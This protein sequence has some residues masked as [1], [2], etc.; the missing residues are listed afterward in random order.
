MPELAAQRERTERELSSRIN[1]TVNR[2]T[3]SL[4]DALGRDSTAALSNTAGALWTP[5]EQA[6]GKDSYWLLLQ[7]YLD[8]YDNIDDEFNSPLADREL[9]NQ[10]QLPAHDGIIFPSVPPT[11]YYLGDLYALQ[12]SQSLARTYVAN[13]INRLIQVANEAS[14]PKHAT[15]IPGTPGATPQTLFT[16]IQFPHPSQL[17]W[18]RKASEIFSPGRTEAIAITNTTEAISKGEGGFIGRTRLE[19]GWQ[20]TAIWQT[21]KDERVC[22]I[23]RPLDGKPESYYA[24]LVGAPPAHPRCRCWQTYRLDFRR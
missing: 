12:A 24:P 3:P 6:L 20:V 1:A 17:D 5:F 11:A 8:A 18:D 7:I 9:T 4:V 21:E 14:S 22:P 19:L 16:P 2:F 15:T 23:C 13:T 10:I